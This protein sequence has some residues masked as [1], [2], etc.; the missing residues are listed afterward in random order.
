MA[1]TRVLLF[2]DVEGSTQ[3]TEQ[4]GDAAASDL[5]AAHDHIARTLTRSWGG[6]EIDKSDGFLL[7][8]ENVGDA[9]A[10][11]LALHCA[12]AELRPPLMARAGIHKGLLVERQIPVDDQATG[13][14]AFEVDG[15]WQRPLPRGS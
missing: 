1:R 15:V 11:A 12:L 2:T 14:R 6:R 7:L 9:T 13:A 5:W 8:F 3:I 4:L 10:C